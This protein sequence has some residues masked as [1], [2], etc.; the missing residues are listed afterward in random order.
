MELLVHFLTEMWIHLLGSIE[1]D[2]LLRDLN[3]KTSA[4]GIIMSD[5]YL[6]F[7]IQDRLSNSTETC[8]MLCT[9]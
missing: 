9:N 6:L 3:V 1:K 5:M 2:G 7:N 4:E 8:L